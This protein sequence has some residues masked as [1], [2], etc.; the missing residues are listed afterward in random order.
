[1]DY[2]GRSD[3]EEI[4]SDLGIQG[5]T[6]EI[7]D[8]IGAIAK[9]L[10]KGVAQREIITNSN[11][12]RA[13]GFPLMSTAVEGVADAAATSL[14]A[15]ADRDCMLKYLFVEAGSGAGALLR[16]VLMTGLTIGG[17]NCIVGSG[18]APVHTAF[19]E[20]QPPKEWDLGALSNG[21]NAVLAL[22]NRAG[23]AVDIS[24]TYLALTTD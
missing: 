9:H 13:R 7:G 18:F 5:D 20:F 17:R 16:G 11:K 2:I 24:A 6:D 21:N 8:V 19:G 1:M 22:L 12:G 4:M 10:K 14:T 23:A 15:T 3:V